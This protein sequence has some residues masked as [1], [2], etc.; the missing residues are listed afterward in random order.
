MDELVFCTLDA[1][2]DSDLHRQPRSQSSKDPCAALPDT[3][4]LA[5]PLEMKVVGGRSSKGQQQRQARTHAFGRIDE[6]ADGSQISAG[7]RG[8]G[9]ECPDQVA[10]PE[11]LVW[12]AIMVTILV[13]RTMTAVG[14]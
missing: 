10:S 4:R 3:A 1:K 8:D 6:R 12:S 9:T 13:I 2:G 5:W 11:S 7:G 14:G